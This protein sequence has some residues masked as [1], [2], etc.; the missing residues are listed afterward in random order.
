VTTAAGASASAAP[1]PVSTW[2]G[3]ADDVCATLD[4]AAELDGFTDV[5]LVVGAAAELVGCVLVVVGVSLWVVLVGSGV[6]VGVGVGSGAG[7]GVGVGVGVGV[8]CALVL[9]VVGVS[10]PPPPPPLLPPK[11]HSPVMTPADTS[12]KYSKR[13][14]V[15]SRP[16]YGQPG[17]SS[18]I[19]ALVVLPPKE[20]VIVLKQYCDFQYVP[21]WAILSATTKSDAW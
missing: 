2:L 8:G 12:E 14:C 11:D 4:G 19:C 16:P 6:G 10:S 7:S 3:A 15:M 21:Y 20:I 9:V 5:L 13:P 17:H 18:T 1:G